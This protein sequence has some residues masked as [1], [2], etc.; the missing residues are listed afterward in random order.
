MCIMVR[1]AINEMPDRVLLIAAA[2]RSARADPVNPGIF[3]RNGVQY[4]QG[5]VETGDMYIGIYSEKSAG[6]LFVPFRPA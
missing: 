5:I 4:Y 1:P 2:Q 3:T 6:N